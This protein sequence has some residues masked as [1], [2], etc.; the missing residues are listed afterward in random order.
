MKTK[1]TKIGFDSFEVYAL[2]SE[3]MI[4]VRGGEDIPCT[5]TKP[6]VKI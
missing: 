4:N 2:T 5:P 1:E 3:E 6:P